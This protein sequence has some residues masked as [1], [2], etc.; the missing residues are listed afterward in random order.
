MNFI[1]CNIVVIL[2]CSARAGCC[3]SRWLTPRA[4]CILRTVRLPLA[5]RVYT[6]RKSI[7]F[8]SFRSRRN[9]F[10]GCE[11]KKSIKKSLRYRVEPR[12]TFAGIHVRVY[13][14]FKNPP[15]NFKPIIA[16]IR[17]FLFRPFTKKRLRRRPR[18]SFSFPSDFYVHVSNNY[19]T[20][21]HDTC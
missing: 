13:E 21:R 6:R 9:Y 5:C 17:L 15:N 8:I 2:F 1:K 19:I 11:K 12:R 18:G 20:Y 3:E 16:D 7:R 10:L 4:V 14:F